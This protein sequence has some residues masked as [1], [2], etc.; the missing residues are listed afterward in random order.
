MTD[1]RQA[2]LDHAI[3]RQLVDRKTMVEH[4]VSHFMSHRDCALCREV[5]QRRNYSKPIAEEREHLATK[6]FEKTDLDHIIMGK[7][8]PGIYGEVVGLVGRDE[9]CGWVSFSGDKNRDVPAVSEGLR[10][11]FGNALDKAKSRG[12][13]IYSDSAPSFRKVCKK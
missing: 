4:D 13:T 8:A 3:T 7:N 6:M 12:F 10:H 11:H 5:E 1:D 2:A 9:K